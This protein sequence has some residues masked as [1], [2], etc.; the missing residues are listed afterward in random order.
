MLKDA[1]KSVRICDEN[2]DDKPPHVLAKHSSHPLRDATHK[3]GK[4]KMVVASKEAVP[5]KLKWAN[6][7][8]SSD[9][10]MVV[11]RRDRF[12]FQFLGLH[13]CKDC[14]QL[15]DHILRTTYLHKIRVRRRLC[16]WCNFSH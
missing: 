3:N 10:L 9:K 6:G 16:T 5:K 4:Q 11:H 14:P 7:P 8:L 1:I 15:T 13:E 12:C 2:V